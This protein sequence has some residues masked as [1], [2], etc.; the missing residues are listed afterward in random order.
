MTC[1]GDEFLGGWLRPTLLGFAALLCLFHPAGCLAQ[2][3]EEAEYRVKLAFLYNFAQFI[4]WPPEAF[5]NP[6]GPLTICVA[7]QN[8]FEGEMAQA[9]NGRQAGGHPIE[10]RRLKRS[11]DPKTCQMIFVRDSERKSTETIL[12]ALK[13]SNTLTVGESK[14]FAESGGVINLTLV[15]NKLRFEVNLNAAAQTRLRISSKLLALAKIVRSERS[16]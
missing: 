6:A 1:R 10:V 15:E 2:I 16:P 8:P 3:D 13:G 7:G 14:G 5:R 11:E 12:A 9:L 4:D